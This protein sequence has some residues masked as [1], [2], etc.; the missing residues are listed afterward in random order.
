MTSQDA[1]SLDATVVH[2]D[3]ASRMRAQ[4]ANASLARTSLVGTPRG[5]MV[6]RVHS[7]KHHS[8]PVIN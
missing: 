4:I 8:A 1:S 5:T 7:W 6:L 2:P 3:P